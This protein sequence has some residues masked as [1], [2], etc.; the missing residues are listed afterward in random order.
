MLSNDIRSAID[1]AVEWAAHRAILKH[2]NLAPHD[3]AL[4]QYGGA[5]VVRQYANFC[6]EFTRLS[7]LKSPFRWDKYAHLF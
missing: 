6:P 2:E 5:T 7:L 3:F 4:S 1:T